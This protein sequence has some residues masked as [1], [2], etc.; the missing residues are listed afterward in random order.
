LRAS[1]IDALIAA[2]RGEESL[3]RVSTCKLQLAT[4][5]QKLYDLAV[6]AFGSDLTLGL[7]DPALAAVTQEEFQFSRIVSVYG[8]SQQMQ[9]NA[10]ATQVL[11]L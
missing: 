6:S 7:L 4:V 10:I 1:A 5:E 2:H 9:L 8:G 3:A 11:G